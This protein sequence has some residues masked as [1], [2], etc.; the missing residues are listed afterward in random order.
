MVLPVAVVAARAASASQDVTY[1]LGLAEVRSP[2][3][4][5]GALGVT[6]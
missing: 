3:H 5:T 4:A 1:L 2:F 6:L